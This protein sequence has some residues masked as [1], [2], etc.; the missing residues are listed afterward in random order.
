MVSGTRSNTPTSPHAATGVIAIAIGA[1]AA[2]GGVRAIATGVRVT[3]GDRAV[4]G[5]ARAIAIGVLAIVTGARAI[6]G[7]RV[8]AIGVRAI[9]GALARYGGDRGRYSGVRVII[10][11]APASIGDGFTLHD[12]GPR[13]RAFLFRMERGNLDE[14]HR[15][16]R[17]SLKRG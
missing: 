2:C 15:A 10:G 13:E 1:H 3:I 6:I 14:T 9:T 17:R 8:T 11:A 5:G 12:K 4:C 7:D 16:L